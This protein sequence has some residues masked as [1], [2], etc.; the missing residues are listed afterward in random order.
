[1]GPAAPGMNVF[2][3]G[4]GMSEGMKILLETYAEPSPANFKRLVSV[5][6]F[7][8]SFAT[9]ELAQQRSANALAHPEHLTSFG[10]AMKSI[11]AYFGLAHRL[12]EITAPTLAI[13]GRD[14]RTVHFENSLRLVAAIPD[15]RL[16]LFNRCGHWAQLEHAAEFNRLV[17][18]FVSNH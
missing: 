9:D 12:A 15:S 13:H 1:M 5:M 16:V 17:A 10:S 7:D 4:G 18:Q 3:P 11:A 8:Q 14:D 6:A 2:S